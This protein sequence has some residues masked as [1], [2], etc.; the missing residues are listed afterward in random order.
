M[1][2]GVLALVGTRKGLFLLRGDDDRRVHGQP[3]PLPVNN[4]A[5]DY[6]GARYGEIGQWVHKLLLHP[7]RPERLWQQDHCGVYRSDD[8]GDSWE[9]L[10]GNG[11]P[12]GFGFPIMIDPNDPDTALVI[13]ERSP[14]VREILVIA[15]LSGG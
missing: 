13:P 2:I 15:M 10:D 1:S 5:A 4:V 11:L 12:S 7:A 8:C 3:R 6:L 9:R 14:G